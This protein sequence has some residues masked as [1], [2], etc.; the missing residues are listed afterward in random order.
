MNGHEVGG[1]SGE[2]TVAALRSAT[3]PIVVHVMRRMQENPESNGGGGGG[4][5]RLGV[6]NGGVQYNPAEVCYDHVGSSLY[7]TL[8]NKLIFIEYT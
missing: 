1:L 6:A 3:E 5:A 4:G 7:S 2:E 8:L